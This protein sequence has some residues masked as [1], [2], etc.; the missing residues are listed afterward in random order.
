MKSWKIALGLGAA[1]VA[2]L[3]ASAGLLTFADDALPAA[4]AVAGVA[5]AAGGLWL[6]RRRVAAARGNCACPSVETV[7]G[8][9]SCGTGANNAC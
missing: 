4:C 5:L 9:S 6:W 1:C 8:Q 3:A 7:S 2:C